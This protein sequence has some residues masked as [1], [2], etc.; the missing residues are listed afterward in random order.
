MKSLRKLAETKGCVISLM[1]PSLIAIIARSYPPSLQRET[2]LHSS[3]LSS[4]CKTAFTITEGKYLTH[5]NS[6]C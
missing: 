5:E 6:S 2:Q 4:L 1:F 3:F